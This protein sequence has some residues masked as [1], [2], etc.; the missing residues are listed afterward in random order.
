[1]TAEAEL[2]KMAAVHFEAKKTG[3]GQ[4]QDGWSLTL[5]IQ[6]LDM[7]P[8]VRDARKGTRYMVALVELDDNDSPLPPAENSGPETCSNAVDKPVTSEAVRGPRKWGELPYVQRAGMLAQDNIFWKFARVKRESEAADY[9]RKHC[10]VN[11]R[12]E[13][14]ANPVAQDLFNELY[15]GLQ[16]YKFMDG[17]QWK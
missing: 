11:S 2:A 6:D 16:D 15:G 3:F 4:A 10:G 8:S 5:R 12:T 17:R 13:I 9:I 1:M 7:P 14:D